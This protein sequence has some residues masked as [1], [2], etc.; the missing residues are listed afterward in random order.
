V[1][2]SA[3]TYLA[4]STIPQLAGQL[5]RVITERLQLTAGTHSRLEIER[6]PNG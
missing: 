1:V 4:S 3:E 5:D 6:P 2:R